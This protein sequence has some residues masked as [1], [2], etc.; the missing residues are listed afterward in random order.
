MQLT[1]PKTQSIP[2][3]INEL[4]NWGSNRKFKINSHALK[5]LISSLIG[6]QKYDELIELAK[7]LAKQRYPYSDRSEIQIKLLT[8]VLTA[9]W[10]GS[11][12]TE[13]KE[14]VKII[15]SS[16]LHF[17]IDLPTPTEFRSFH[18]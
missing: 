6:S 13:C 14:L 17:S 2:A 9:L 15:K 8:E 10:K 16:N 11:K 7:I 5:K 3:N 12:K 4:V 1:S 18:L